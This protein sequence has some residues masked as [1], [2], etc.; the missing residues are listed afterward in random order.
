MALYKSLQGF[1]PKDKKEPTPES[2]IRTLQEYFFLSITDMVRDSRDKKFKCPVQVYISCFAYNDDDTFEAPS[3][4]TS[5]LASLQYL[6]RCI[7]LYQANILTNVDG[8]M[9]VLE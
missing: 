1:H 4:V 3:Q 9:G 8:N 2:I 6:L 7:V 5:L